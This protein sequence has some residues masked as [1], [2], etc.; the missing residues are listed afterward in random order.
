[1]S[2]FYVYP[3]NII[4]NTFTMDNEQLHYLV[5]VRRF[6]VNDEIKLFDGLG[7]VF[8]GKITEIT[9]NK[10]HGV[11]LNKQTFIKTSVEVYLYCA[12]AKGER[13]EW[14]IE[15]AAEIGITTFIP[16]ITKRSVITSFSANKYERLNKISISASCQCGRADIMK[17]EQPLL[18][19]DAI[20]NNT[21]KNSIS[22]LAWESEDK[23]TIDDIYKTNKDIKKIN[24]FIGPEGGFEPNETEQAKNN[25]FYT[26]TLGK[27]ILRIETAAIAESDLI[28][29]KWI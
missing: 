3:K 2:H 29:N 14:L 25:N 15:K 12:I 21:D 16:L 13:T 19:S 5:N 9:K 8:S 20:K 7:N 18:F 24:I 1:M 17:I 26:I 28:L 22:I 4:N 27:N 6:A 11:I 10:L 23:Q